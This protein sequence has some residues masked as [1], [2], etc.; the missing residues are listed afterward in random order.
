MEASRLDRR[1]AE[2]REED[3]SY[4]MVMSLEP[5]P[6]DG[7]DVLSAIIRAIVRFSEAQLSA[8]LPPS[9][10]CLRSLGNIPRAIFDGS[11]FT[12]SRAA[13]TSAPDLAECFL[14]D[15]ELIAADWCGKS[16][17]GSRE[18]GSRDSRLSDSW[19]SSILSN[20]VPKNLSRQWH[21]NFEAHYKRIAGPEDDRAYL[22]TSFRDAVCEWQ[23]CL[24][25]R[26]EGGLR[27][28]S[29]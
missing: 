6:T 29:I 21:P 15:K 27:K 25:A 2:V 7:G 5:S 22:E 23:G 3:Y 24:A 18:P 14:I 20:P 13:R 11:R 10:A 8:T 9:A 4:Y 19:R 1:L 17:A 26:S 16:M 12:A 28:D